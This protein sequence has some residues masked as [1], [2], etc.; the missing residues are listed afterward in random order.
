MATQPGLA[1]P[2]AVFVKPQLSQNARMNVHSFA[3]VH[4]HG[5]PTPRLSGAELSKRLRDLLQLKCSCCIKDLIAQGHK[6]LREENEEASL[7]G[8]FYLATAYELYCNLDIQEYKFD[9][10][11][12]NEYL[13]K[14]ENSLKEGENLL[15]YFAAQENLSVFIYLF[16]ERQNIK[17]HLNALA[18][19]VIKETPL[20]VAI[21]MGSIPIVQFLLKEG[22]DI[23]KAGDGQ[24]AKTVLHAAVEYGQEEIVDLLLKHKDIPQILNAAQGEKGYTALHL[25]A[26]KG[27]FSILCKL[28]NY[29]AHTE[30]PD[31]L[32]LTPLETL[33]EQE[34][35]DFKMQD[36][37]A[38]ILLS[39]KDPSFFQLDNPSLKTCFIN[40]LKHGLPNVA[41]KLAANGLPQQEEQECSFL[42]IAAEAAFPRA[43]SVALSPKEEHAEKRAAY[44]ELIYWLLAEK[45]MD[46]NQKFKNSPDFLVH[47]I[48][49]AG[50]S[51]LLSLLIE[52]KVDLKIL[53]SSQNNALH[54]ACRSP[55]DCVDIVRILVGY[56]PTRAEA[57]NS[58]ERS[59]LHLAALDGNEKSVQCLLN[60]PTHQ[61]K[62]N[63]Q[64]KDGNTPLHLVVIAG[65]IASLEARE[66]YCKISEALVK[67]GADLEILNQEKKTAL[68][69]AFKSGNE[70]I[71]QTLVQAKINLQTLIGSLQGLYLSQETLSIFKI[72]ASQEWE[73]KVP[74]EEIY[75]RLGIIENQERKTRDQALDK[76]SEYLQDARIPTHETIF[77]PKKNIEIEQLFKHASLEKKEAKRVYIQG[78]AGIGKSTL[79]HYIAYHWAK[80]D[81]WQGLF[82]CLFW[83]PLRNF[84]PE[85]YP[86]NQGYTPADLIA[87]EYEGK[88]D[89]QVIEACIN[90]VAFREKTLLV[91][92]GYDELSAEEQGNTSLAKAFQKL[93][94]L[95]PHILITSRPGSCS[96]DRSCELELLGFDK[97]GVDCYIDKFFAQVQAEEKKANL[98]RLLESS[99]NVSSLAHIPINLTLL[100]CLFNEDPEF[101]NSD[102]PITMT[103]IYERIVN[104]MYKWFMLRRIDQ[105]LSKQTKKSILPEKDLRQNNPEVFN[106]ATVFEKMAYFAMKHDTLYLKKE[107][108]DNFRG[109]TI[110]SD[111]VTDCGLVRIPEAEEK[112]YFIHLT[113]QEFLT[114]SKVANRYL[115]GKREACQNFVRDYKFE[116]RYGLVFRMI[117]GCLSLAASN[118]RRYADADALKSFFDDL[119]SAPHDLAVRSE[120]SL[121]AECFEECQNPA[122][123]KQ[124]EGFIELVKD[125]IK[126]LSLL[127]LDFPRL[128]RNKNILNHFKVIRAIRELFSASQTRENT[129]RNLLQILEAGQRLAP[130]IVRVIVETLKDPDVDSITKRSAAQALT[131]VAQQGGQ[132]AKETLAALTQMLQEGDD[133]A[134]RHAANVLTA[135]AQQGDQ[136]AKEALAALIHMLQEGDSAAKSSAAK[137]LAAGAQQ[138]RQLPKEAL[139][140]LIHMLQEGDSAAKR[141]AAQ[142][143]VEGAQ[144]GA[145][146]PKEVLPALIQMLQEGDLFVKIYAA[147]ALTAGAQQGAQ[148][149]KEALSALIQMLQEGDFTTQRHAGQALAAVVQQGG[150]LAQQ[151]LAVLTQMLQE[152]N[153]TAK[154]CAAEALAKGAQQGDQLPKET[155]PALIQMLQ[156]GDDFAKRYAAE[157]LAAA[158]Q[159]GD[160]LPKDTLP[161]LI[162]IL[163]EGDPAAKSSA[164][165]VLAAGAQQGVQ[166]PKE[167]LPALLQM[168]QKGDDSAKWYAGQ[169][170][171]AVAQQGGQL[172]KE[173]LDALIQML[174]EG[175]F[176]AK[177]CAVQVLAAVAQQGG[178]LPTETL[179]ALAQM[180]QEGNSTRRYA[181]YHVLA[182]IHKNA[183]LKMDLEV[184]AKVCFFSEDSFSA[185][186]QHLQ[187]SD[188]RTTHISKDKLMLNCEEIRKKLPTE[189]A[190]WRELLDSLGTAGSS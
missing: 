54:H 96:F 18:G 113:F 122:I 124:Y 127:G 107:E 135:V 145:Q 95:F 46:P 180:L 47:R 71:I 90:N 99:P 187:I 185:K 35:L 52:L 177:R 147:E 83:I 6:L 3:I 163:Q 37:C 136:L 39:K 88:I 68:A 4:Q 106:I 2:Q 30:L 141:C 56:D 12:L 157:A 105:G 22:A 82:S 188:K 131:A 173:T 161:A 72:K 10:Q 32:H 80:K 89:R 43:D 174:Q 151:A 16:A 189:L 142:A 85:K 92:D 117:A 38:C 133:F 61:I 78:A 184:I 146:L 53:D 130:E 55:T 21:R 15:H 167:A 25:A 94:K 50:C 24:Y 121:I 26:D 190:V 153:L 125:Y 41:K 186:N 69:L 51:A 101:F 149:P 58:D 36:K 123:V 63:Q 150:Q 158:A 154:R 116:P 14:V 164:A 76:P 75:V 172:P 100:C 132:L 59:P 70:A 40:A 86:A 175:D 152:G 171:A 119:F 128:L 120:L 11:A 168:L 77:E 183:L 65:G 8:G 28:I 137:A 115:Q 87:K 143:L 159:Q 166:L 13:D 19:G 112:G 93:K 5:T 9:R 118:N 129:L 7:H 1:H 155:L 176:T 114:A 48:C 23:K 165:H 20:H 104:W 29:G 181:A 17:S 182:L 169:A 108:I 33:L 98:Y 79:C 31:V 134:K 66:H 62:L 148:L 91:L 102:Q 44:I 57:K 103:S 97:K 140:A 160:Q 111:D 67:K 179:D 162:Q 110:T 27:Y 126:H 139:A 64:D 34:N 178:Q 138:G 109:G 74:L 60:Q 144:Q 156:E 73:F 45:R 81:L 84:T 49:Y 42:E 170:L